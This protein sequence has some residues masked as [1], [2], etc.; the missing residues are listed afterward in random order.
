MGWFT[1]ADG[2]S[3]KAQAALQRLAD[4]G[5]SEAAGVADTLNTIAE[6]GDGQETDEHLVGCA[7]EIRDYAVSFIQEVRGEEPCK[8]ERYMRIAKDTKKEF[9][10]SK[11]E[12]TWAWYDRAEA[13][14]L[15]NWHTGY[16]SF[17]ECLVDAV[18]PYMEPHVD[19][20][21]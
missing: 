8:L 4:C 12:G 1:P 5:S 3:D 21:D 2:L 13:H 20:D 7:E 15:H 19:D 18:E 6:N 9:S 16:P 14:N 11:A 10:Y 17:W